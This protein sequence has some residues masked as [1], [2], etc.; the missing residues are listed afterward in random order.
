LEGRQIAHV[1]HYLS[2]RRP[3]LALLR[4]HDHVHPIAGVGRGERAIEPPRLR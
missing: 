3:R 4:E 1:H 2:A